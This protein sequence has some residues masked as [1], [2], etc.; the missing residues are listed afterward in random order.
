M[1]RFKCALLS[2]LCTV[3][4]FF[5]P[6]M[7]EQVQAGVIYFYGRV[8]E[9]P[10]QMDAVN[11]HIIMD[12][13]NKRAVRISTQQIEQGNFHNENIRSAQLKY[14]NPQKTLAILEVNYR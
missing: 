6:A 11:S 12:C 9:A 5:S 3:P 4:V 13:P 1:K 7:A 2:A 8:V 14:I 10:C